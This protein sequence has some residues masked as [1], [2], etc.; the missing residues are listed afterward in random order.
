MPDAPH[1]ANQGNK[2]KHVGDDDKSQQLQNQVKESE[3]HN[4][5]RNAANDLH[6]EPEILRRVGGPVESHNPVLCPYFITIE[7]VP[8]SGDVLLVLPVS[9]LEAYYT[10][11][12][13]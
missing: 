12:G 13:F 3:K 11:S 9:C 2:D 10:S 8:L 1:A 7:S 5:A 6:Y 4:R